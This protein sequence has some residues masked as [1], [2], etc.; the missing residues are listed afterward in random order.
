VKLGQNACSSAYTVMN[1]GP[2]R[3]VLFIY[4]RKSRFIVLDSM[5]DIALI[6]RGLFLTLYR[7]QFC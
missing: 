2:L 6:A 7:S 1:G 4:L 5:S 3:L